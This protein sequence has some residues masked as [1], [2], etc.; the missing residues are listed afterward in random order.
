MAV[1]FFKPGVGRVV[2][3]FVF[4][5][6]LLVASLPAASP[7]YNK[8]GADTRGK[9]TATGERVNQW[10]VLYEKS[11]LGFIGS[12]GGDNFAGEFKQFNAIIDFDPEHPEQGYFDVTIDTTSITTFNEE[13]DSVLGD[14]DWFSFKKFPESSYITSQITHIKSNQFIA[15]GKLSLKGIEKQIALRFTWGDYKNGEV[16]VTGYARM[17][18]EADIHRLDFAIGEG[19]WAEDESIGTEVVVKV[20]LVL[21][22]L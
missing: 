7:E 4:T 20:D 13:R 15:Q 6:V 11:K 18:A 5:S 1:S 14:A 22:K 21:T 17:F 16:T 3:G 10:Q 12:Y 2:Y 19:D 9:V 8:P